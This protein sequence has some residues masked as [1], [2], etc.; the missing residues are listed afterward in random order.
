MIYIFR[1][2]RHTTCSYT[3]T[4]GT[5]IAFNKCTFLG[6]E[7]ENSDGALATGAANM[8]SEVNLDSTNQLYAQMDCFDENNI[9]LNAKFNNTVPAINSL[10]PLGAIT[11][12]EAVGP[13]TKRYMDGK[14]LVL[15]RHPT[16]W[17][18]DKQVA[19]TLREISRTGAVTTTPLGA[20]FGTATLTDGGSDYVNGGIN[21]YFEFELT[22]DHD[23]LQ[24]S[25]DPA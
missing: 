24:S 8:D 5:E 2:S 6:C 21:L 10:I 19:I 4:I 3:F 11:T 9:I 12:Q 23:Y 17:A 18:A 25:F 15:I 20:A 16:V 14:G 22:T 7:I 13:T 1:M